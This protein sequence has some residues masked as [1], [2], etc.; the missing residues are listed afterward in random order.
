[1]PCFIELRK[2]LRIFAIPTPS[3]VIADGRTEGGEERVIIV[4]SLRDIRGNPRG[5]TTATH[6]YLDGGEKKN[7]SRGNNYSNKN[8]I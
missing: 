1:M 2:S 4:T 6:D 8:E 5:V 3:S 7:T